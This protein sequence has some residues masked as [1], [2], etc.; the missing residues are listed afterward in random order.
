MKQVG[1]LSEKIELKTKTLA[2]DTA[3]DKSTKVDFDTKLKTLEDRTK[4]SFTKVKNDFKTLTE[5]LALS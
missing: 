1:E 3:E 2:L 4:G 5:T